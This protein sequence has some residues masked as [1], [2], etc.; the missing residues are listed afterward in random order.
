MNLDF[1]QSGLDFQESDSISDRAVSISSSL[2]KCLSEFVTSN[3]QNL[4]RFSFDVSIS[5]RL[6]LISGRAIAGPS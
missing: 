3:C 2:V 6:V 5:S 1:R 4:G